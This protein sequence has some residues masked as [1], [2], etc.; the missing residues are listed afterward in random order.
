M[1]ASNQATDEYL[2]QNQSNP[3]AFMDVLKGS[4]LPAQ[5]PQIPF[6][7]QDRSPASMEEVLPENYNE[8]AQE[9]AQSQLP[10]NSPMSDGA[11]DKYAKILEQIKAMTHGFSI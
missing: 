7:P 8:L 10:P 11:G 3:M 6:A 2:E 9:E 1:D 5:E 4:I